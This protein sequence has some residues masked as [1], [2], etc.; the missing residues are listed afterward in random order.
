MVVDFA[1]NL[2]FRESFRRTRKAEVLAHS[3]LPAVLSTK[4]GVGATQG[5]LQRRV[6]TKDAAGNQKF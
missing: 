4:A 2:L 3:T 6:A 5:V 1:A